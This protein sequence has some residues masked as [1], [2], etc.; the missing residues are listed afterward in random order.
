MVVLDLKLL[1]FQNG[2]TKKNILSLSG[3]LLF[4]CAFGFSLRKVKF[5]KSYLPPLLS[6]L[7]FHNEY[8]CEYLTAALMLSSHNKKSYQL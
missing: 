5:N 2:N 6:L 1:L 8:L 7:E 4:Q 3:E